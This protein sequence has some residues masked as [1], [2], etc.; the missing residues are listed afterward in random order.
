MFKP[1]QMLE[2]LSETW[3]VWLIFTVVALAGYC[4]YWYLFGQ[5][6]YRAV[7]GKAQVK[8]GRLGKW[9][10]LEQHLHNEHDGS[11]CLK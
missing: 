2:F 6:I 4:L 7:A 3:K 11:E 10:D 8:H 5:R 9:E 1:E